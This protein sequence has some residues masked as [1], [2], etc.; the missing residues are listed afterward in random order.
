LVLRKHGITRAL[1][2]GSGDIVAGDPP[3]GKSGWRIGIAA[4]AKP[5]EKPTRFLLLK[6]AAVATSGDAYQSVTI[7][8]KRYSHIVDPK[9]GFGLTH[10]SSVT[11]IANNGTT[12]D[13]LASAV[14]VLGPREGLKRIEC[15][16]QAAA[17]IM[18]LNNNKPEAIE[19]TRFCR[20][21]SDK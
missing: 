5:Q 10:R 17:L 21:E 8:G 12:A 1:I 9:T 19:S 4:L 13:A 14:S 3:P 15:T 16:P 6:N 18:T 2:D 11:V 7:D 20:Y